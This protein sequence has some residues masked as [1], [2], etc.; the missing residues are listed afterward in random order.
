MYEPSSSRL[1]SFERFVWRVGKHVGCVVAIMALSVLA[2]SAGF[3]L[4]EG[5]SFDEAI[6]SAAHILAGLGLIQFPETYAGRL[7]AAMF[8]LYANLFFLAAFSVIF[9]PIVHRI[10]HK[11]HLD[12]D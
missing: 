6:L 10:L 1:I 11:L 12:T 4:I 2:G 3:A 5:Y 9:A 8:G 7:F